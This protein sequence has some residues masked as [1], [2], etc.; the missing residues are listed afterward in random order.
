MRLLATTLAVVFVAACGGDHAGTGDGGNG[1]EGGSG[2]N[3]ECINTPGPAL[4][5][6]NVQLGPNVKLTKIATLDGS[7]ASALLVT[8]PPNDGRLFVLQQS[9]EIR[10]IEDGQLKAT[11]FVSL[12]NV[13]L[14]EAPPG[15]RG[16]L[17]LAFHPNYACNGQ[18]FVYYTTSNADVLARYTVSQGDIDKA[19]ATSGEVILSIPDPFEN[20]NGGMIEFGNDGL[21]Y[22]S[23]GDGGSANDPR[24]NG[25][26]ILRSSPSCAASMC[27]PLLA[28]ILRIDVD[29]PAGGKMYGIPSNN[30]YAT[31]GLGEPEILI[32]GL[33]NPWRWSFDRMTGDMYIGDVGQDTIEELDVIPKAQIDGAP[34]APVN[35]GW[36]IYEGNAMFRP[37]GTNCNNNGTCSAT[38]LT[39]PLF[40]RD[41]ANDNWKA[42]IGGQVYRGQNYPGL[43]GNYYFTDYNANTLVQA[44][45]HAMGPSLSTTEIAG[46]TFTGASSLHADA[47]GELYLTDIKGN[48]WQLQA[49]P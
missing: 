36:S 15:E 46:T 19:D 48:I 44:T 41:H 22:I 49:T 8:A 39:A 37:N 13:V 9:G 16:L 24:L 38:G 25:Q 21:L 26:A 11:P 3:G 20:H 1:G 29:H 31:G 4:P 6:A 30:P 34:N 23:V 33:R 42:I 28:K 43:V 5:A 7:P 14:A 10:I 45:Y 12:D 47:A 40:T 35:M 17:G 27:E 18:F 2:S 32:R